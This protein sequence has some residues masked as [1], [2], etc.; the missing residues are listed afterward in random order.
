MSSLSLS[1]LQTIGLFVSGA[2]QQIGRPKGGVWWN[3]NEPKMKFCSRKSR[4]MFVHLFSSLR[5]VES[6]C[7]LVLYGHTARVWLA[8]PLPHCIISVGEDAVCRVWGYDGKI[9]T[10]F[11]GHKG[12]SIWSMAVD[13]QRSVLASSTNNL[14]C[15]CE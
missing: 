13:R 8:R 4:F 7:L 14:L 2:F 15:V 12:K 10:T 1:L 11:R 3:Q 9:W 5:L 6:N